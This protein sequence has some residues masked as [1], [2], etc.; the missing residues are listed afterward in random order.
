MATQTDGQQREREILTFEL[1]LGARLDLLWLSYGFNQLLN[2]HTVLIT[3]ITGTTGQKLVQVQ[4]KS[5]A[6][7]SAIRCQINAIE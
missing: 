5:K 4:L 3:S 1:P 7:L 6:F 2:N